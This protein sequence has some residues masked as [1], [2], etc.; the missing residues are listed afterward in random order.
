VG[1]PDD[2]GPVVAPLVGASGQEIAAGG[3]GQGEEKGENGCDSDRWA[4]DITEHEYNYKVR[5]SSRSRKT[6]P[7]FSREVQAGK[8]G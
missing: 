1:N 2:H 5:F 4:T 6:V 8:R 3:K 7:P